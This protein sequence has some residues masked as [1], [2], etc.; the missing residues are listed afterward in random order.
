MKRLIPLA[1]L[2][3]IIGCTSFSTNLF[4]AEQTA[5]SAAMAAYSGYTQ[6]LASG[7]LKLSATDS[8]AIKAAR[9]DFAASVGVL[10]TFRL[11][12]ETNATDATK[13]AAQAALAAALANSSNLVWL[14]HRI[15]S[16]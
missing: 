14:I 12:Y 9:L 10:E 6:A 13:S 11:S 2:L 3:A 4:R 16:Q 5:T 15:Q 1:V 7:S 8:N